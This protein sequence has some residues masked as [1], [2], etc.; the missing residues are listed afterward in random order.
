M[1]AQYRDQLEQLRNRY[2][3][4]RTITAQFVGE[5]LDLFEAAVTDLQTEHV[6]RMAE[7]ERQH[8][9][10]LARSEDRTARAEKRVGD[11]E[12]ARLAIR[13]SHETIDA[14][15]LVK[16]TAPRG[17]Y[18]SGEESKYARPWT[19]AELEDIAYRLRLGGGVD[20]TEVRFQHD[21]TEATIPFPE[22]VLD[23]PSR[24]AS[25]ADDQNPTPRRRLTR[26]ET[27]YVAGFLGAVA[28][29]IVLLATR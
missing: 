8:G 21:H 27:F 25:P 6:A 20:E 14:G 7:A 10:H 26:L 19:L 15:V 28:A 22:L 4:R 12:A 16:I 29:A 23:S 18:S 3:D 5:T 11:L 2:S 13:Q 24:K 1:P 17:H 9:I